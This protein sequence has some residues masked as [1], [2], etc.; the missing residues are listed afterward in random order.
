MAET[1]LP[2]GAMPDVAPGDL[3]RD[4]AVTARGDGR[5][6]A[7]VPEAWRIMYA[8]GGVSMAVAVRAVQAEIDRPDLDLLSAHA[9]FC[10]PV[11]CTDLEIEATTLR[12]GRTAAQGRADLRVAGSDQLGIAATAT[13]G[14][15]QPAPIAYVDTVLPEGAGRPE[16]H[17]PPPPKTADDPF[18]PL[19][20][21][22]Q[23]DWRPAIGHRWWDDAE[24]W[25]PGPA[26]AGSWTRLTVD[27]VLPDGSWD[28]VS[29]CVPADTV[30]MAIGQHLGPGD[31][32]DDDHAFF[33]LTL[34]LSLQVFAAQTSPWVFQHV[35]AP[36]AGDGYAWGHVELF[37]EDGVLLGVA[38]QRARLRMFRP[39]DGFLA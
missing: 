26:R 6:T 30:G 34:E 15:R 13:F 3:C 16:D 38:D 39:G 29:L 31:G 27:P 22:Q 12:S 10:S 2:D 32:T 23:T 33:T 28:P 20:F 11:P 14:Q 35:R 19:P 1:T 5:Y 36:A 17:D 4:T 8:F 9:L 25:R 37:G 18:P 24:A 21:H 7:S